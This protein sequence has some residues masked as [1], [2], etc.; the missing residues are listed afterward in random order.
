ML[1]ACR[2]DEADTSSKCGKRPAALLIATSDMHD[3]MSCV[4]ELA[5]GF[6]WSRRIAGASPGSFSGGMDL[7]SRTNARADQSQLF[8]RPH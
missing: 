7:G 6:T 8:F 5:V 2:R 1:A 3:T 4:V